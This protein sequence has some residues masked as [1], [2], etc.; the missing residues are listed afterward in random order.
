MD[1]ILVIVGFVLFVGL[2]FMWVI[3]KDLRRTEALKSIAKAKGFSFIESE[4]PVIIKQKFN[5]LPIFDKGNR[6]T[7][8]N[9]MKGEVDGIEVWISDY[10][11]WGQVKDAHDRYIDSSHKEHQ[12]LICLLL[13]G[14]NLP[15]F[16]ITLELGMGSR[17][18][19]YNLKEAIDFEDNPGFNKK[20]NVCTSRE[21]DISTVKNLVTKE[22]QSIFGNY[23]YL[24]LEVGGNKMVLTNYSASIKP[25]DLESYINSTLSMAK[26]FSSLAH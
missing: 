20:Y 6:S 7:T 4:D 21:P 12:T 26:I 5:P 10:I 14:L 8:S 24:K 13:P 16:D 19:A 22:V 1:I 25:G 17:P 11:Y 18:S 9:L 3:K 23:K 2:L 15:A